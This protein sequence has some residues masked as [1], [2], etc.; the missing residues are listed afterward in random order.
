M[1]V[2][3]VETATDCSQ[4]LNYK[5]PVILFIM[6]P[7]EV[8]EIAFRGPVE[9]QTQNRI[10]TVRGLLG[11]IFRQLRDAIEINAPSS[12]SGQG[13]VRDIKLPINDRSHLQ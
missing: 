5:G 12:C 11:F 2:Q 3:A 6:A 7:Q 1:L 10:I 8:S 4:C 9:N 13:T